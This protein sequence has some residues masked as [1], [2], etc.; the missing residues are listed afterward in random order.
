MVIT[1][2]IRGHEELTLKGTTSEGVMFEVKADSFPDHSDK[3]GKNVVWPVERNPRNCAQC[4]FF[5]GPVVKGEKAFCRN[6]NK[7]IEKIDSCDSGPMVL[8]PISTQA[9][10]MPITGEGVLIFSGRLRESGL[11]ENIREMET[12]RVMKGSQIKL[13]RIDKILTQVA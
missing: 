1:E 11:P 13:R 7:Y 10:Q 6:S 9:I 3:V 8:D 12:S 4:I 5:E 2:R